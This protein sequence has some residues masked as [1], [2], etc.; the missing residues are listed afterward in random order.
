MEYWSE[1]YNQ[2]PTFLPG[3]QSKVYP[4]A[5]PSL[6]YP[7]DPGVPNTL[8]PSSNRFSPR[9]GLAWS[10]GT[11]PGFLGKIVGGPGKTSIRAGYGI[12]YSVV[13]GN[14]MAV[15]EPQPPYGLSYTSPGPPLFATPYMT[16]SN[17]Q[18]LGN[19]FPLTFPPLNATAAHPSTSGI[20]FSIYVPQAGMTAPVPW[21]TYNYNENYFLSIERQ[22]TDHT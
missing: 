19:P 16:A 5:L 13:E 17:G 7:T 21:N 20:D 14:I 9:I 6:V 2:I 10:P 3:Q 12:F 22:V 8:V 18:F 11:A 15:D 4:T 1:K